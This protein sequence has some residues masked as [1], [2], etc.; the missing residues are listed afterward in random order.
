[1][2]GIMKVL[3]APGDVLAWNTKTIIMA[4]F[5]AAT[6]FIRCPLQ[7]FIDSSLQPFLTGL[8]TTHNVLTP[9]ALTKT[10]LASF[11]SF[12]RTFGVGSC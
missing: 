3:K 7:L 2:I 6:S 10:V 12:V 4:T 8:S 5:K 9:Y 11:H 1:M